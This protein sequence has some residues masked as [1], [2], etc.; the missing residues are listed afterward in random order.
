MGSTLILILGTARNKTVSCHA[1]LKQGVDKLCLCVVLLKFWS[2]SLSIHHPACICAWKRWRSSK[3]AVCR[4]GRDPAVWDPISSSYFT[5]SLHCTN[6][7]TI[8]VLVENISFAFSAQNTLSLGKGKKQKSNKPNNKNKN[9]KKER[10]ETEI[11]L[12]LQILYMHIVL[13]QKILKYN[14]QDEIFLPYI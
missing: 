12:D 2:Y 11:R 1:W 13:K 9:K 3:A 7:H 6:S 8:I 5:C 14:K 10:R 4:T